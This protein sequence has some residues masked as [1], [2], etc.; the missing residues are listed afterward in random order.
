MKTVSIS[1]PKKDVL[2]Q[3]NLRNYYAGESAKVGDT[4]EVATKMQTS[5]DNFDVLNK[6][7][8][9]AC[10]KLVDVL[11]PVCVDV[12]FKETEG[13]DSDSATLDYSIKVSDLYAESQNDV[14]KAGAFEYLVNWAIF[15]WLTLAFP[16]ASQQYFQRCQL[17][18]EGIRA[19][20]NKRLKPSEK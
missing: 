19:R 20:I 6:Y 14:I 7:L 8:T 18:E 2:L 3:V 5:E 10:S 15:E 16:S 9:S 11:N 17:I 1:I 13:N 12:T 4:M